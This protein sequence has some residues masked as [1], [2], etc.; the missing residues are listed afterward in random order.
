M[1]LGH[2]LLF[3]T[4]TFI[5]PMFAIIDLSFDIPLKDAIAGVF[6]QYTMFVTGDIPASELYWLIGGAGA[7]RSIVPGGGG[8]E[9]G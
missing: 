1:L 2:F 5:F 7:D 4:A 6:Y 8:A 3:A 9:S